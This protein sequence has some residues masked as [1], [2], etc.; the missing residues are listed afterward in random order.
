MI[1]FHEHACVHTGLGAF[2]ESSSGCRRSLTSNLGFL[3]M[4]ISELVLIEAADINSHFFLVKK[5]K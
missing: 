3:S 5:I 4:H 2:S 1:T